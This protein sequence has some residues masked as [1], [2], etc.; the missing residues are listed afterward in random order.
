MTSDRAYV[1][2]GGF[3]GG[4]AVAAWFAVRGLRRW[5]V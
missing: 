5:S 1:I 2:A 3:L 4:L